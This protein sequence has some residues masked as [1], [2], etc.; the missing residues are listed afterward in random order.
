MCFVH[1]PGGIQG[2]FPLATLLV[3]GGSNGP[4]ESG[5]AATPLPSQLIPTI[6]RRDARIDERRQITF[7]DGFKISHSQEDSTGLVFDPLRVDQTVE[8]GATEEWVI[9]NDTP[10]WH[11]FHIHVNDFQVVSSNSQAQLEPFVYY[12]DTMP[13]P[14]WVG[15]VPGEVVVLIPFLDF[16]GKFVF[17]CHI[18][19]H[20]DGGMMGVVEVVQPVAVTSNGFEPVLAEVVAGTTV[21]WTNRDTSPH[22]VTADDGSFDS[23]QLDPGDTF[24]HTFDSPGAVAHHCALHPDIRATVVVT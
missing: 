12:K 17:H 22:T 14:P 4:E 6:D 13:L 19:G 9:R 10:A 5:V 8:L 2:E 20:E 15:D 16:T 11:P 3:E 24:S 21:R 23:A 7:R 18:L 1:W